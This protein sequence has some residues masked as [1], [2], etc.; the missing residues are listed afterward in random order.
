MPSE[1]TMQ[2]QVKSSQFQEYTE[3]IEKLKKDLLAARGKDGFFIAEENYMYAS[4]ILFD[5]Y[6]FIIVIIIFRETITVNFS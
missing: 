2:I 1:R 6:L 3:E 5:C 4:S